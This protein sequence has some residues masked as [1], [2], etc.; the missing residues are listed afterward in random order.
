MPFAKVVAAKC[1]RYERTRRRYDAAGHS[2]LARIHWRGYLQARLQTELSTD[3]TF[4][5]PLIE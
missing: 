4:P 1:D 2:D 5:H 3:A